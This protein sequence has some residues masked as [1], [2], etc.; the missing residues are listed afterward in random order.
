[1][2]LIFESDAEFNDYVTAQ[3][4]GQGLSAEKVASFYDLL[5]N[6]LVLRLRECKTFATPLH[7]AVHQQAHNRGVLQR[8]APV[9]AWFNEGLATG[10]EG[11]GERL[12]SGPKTFNRR[13]AALAV[14]AKQTS[15]ADIVREDAAFQG[16]I[17]AGEAYAQAWALHWWL[18]T[19]H[20]PAY[21]KLLQHYTGLEPL[22]AVSPEDR[23]KTFVE[24]VEHL[25]QNLQAD[26]LREANRL[27]RR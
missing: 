8:L 9:P 22:T 1:M 4:A 5:S 23:E 11:D 18:Y 3:T 14:A 26:F 6:R 25:P 15:W 21:R 2:V 19:R 10:F 27:L 17:L 20:R 12:K 7:E 13:Y 24:L 16:D